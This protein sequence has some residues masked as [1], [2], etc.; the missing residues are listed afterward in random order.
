MMKKK[1]L[2]S[3]EPEFFYTF[4]ENISQC[5]ALGTL[6]GFKLTILLCS[7]TKK[8]TGIVMYNRALKF[9]ICNE[10]GI[11]M[12][13]LSNELTRLKKAHIIS[14]ENKEC[15]VS[16]IFYWYGDLKHRTRLLRRKDIQDKFSFN[17]IK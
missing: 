17:L 10:L 4:Y 8:N 3:N 2:N 15:M 13:Y 16:P 14:I 9:D 12:Q 6:L 11:G 7:K 1:E 5:K